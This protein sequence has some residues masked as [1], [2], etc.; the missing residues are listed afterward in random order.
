[1][2]MPVVLSSN[3]VVYSPH[4]GKILSEY[5]ARLAASKKHKVNEKKFHEEVLQALIPNYSLAA[6]YQFVGRFKT[7]AGLVAQNAMILLGDKPIPGMEEG[8]IL[9]SLMSNEVATQVGIQRALNI[10]AKMLSKVNK[11]PELIPLKDAVE[12]LFK[13]MKAQDSRIAALGKVRADNRE[14]L[15]FER[16]FGQA[17]YEENNEGA[18][19]QN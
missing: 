6:W 3:R 10:G 13:A 17:A 19:V 9:D 2:A 11:S 16:A 18:A 7:T 4:Y 14:T 8:K 15:K 12:L 1:M 5:N